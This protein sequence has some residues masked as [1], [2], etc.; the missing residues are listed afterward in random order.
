MGCLLMGQYASSLFSF[1]ISKFRMTINWGKEQFN[2]ELA[3]DR[4]NA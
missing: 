2:T 1:E 3:N 4:F